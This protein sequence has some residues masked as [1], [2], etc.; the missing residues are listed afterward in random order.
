MKATESY[1][2]D[3][4][5]SNEGLKSDFRLVP[6]DGSHFIEAL[7]AAYGDLANHLHPDNEVTRRFNDPHYLRSAYPFSDPHSAVL[8]QMIR[9]S[10]ATT[11]PDL[12]IKASK[13]HMDVCRFIQPDEGQME[14]HIP[15]YRRF[16][17]GEGREGRSRFIF[18]T[19]L[20]PTEVVRGTLEGL[21]PIHKLRKSVW[22]SDPWIRQRAHEAVE[23]AIATGTH[24]LV[25]VPNGQWVQVDPNTIHRAGPIEK[26]GVRI[27]VVVEYQGELLDF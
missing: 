2:S 25:K 10:L 7:Q 20:A 13:V 19:A 24:E 5:D 6:E 9:E 26:P 16:H 14:D 12:F 11:V 4:F 3:Y 27:R 22:S 18:S 17:Y 1:R 8:F 15:D 21:P 23:E